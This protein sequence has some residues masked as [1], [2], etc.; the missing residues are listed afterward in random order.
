MPTVRVTSGWVISEGNRGRLAS[1]S[2]ATTARSR[3]AEPE[4]RTSSTFPTRPSA[5]TVKR[6]IAR[7]SS[8]RRLASSGNV[9]CSA[10]QAATAPRHPGLTV[11]GAASAACAGGAAAFGNAGAGAGVDEGCR[12]AARRV[13]GRDGDTARTGSGTADGGWGAGF[14]GEAAIRVSARDGRS[15]TAGVSGSGLPTSVA[16]GTGSARLGG[17]ASSGVGAIASGGGS[18]AAA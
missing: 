12:V 8:P 7:P 14:S 4:L 3:M 13:G 1:R 15:T 17:G 16:S 11:T 18:G 9:L 10:S 6:T 5:P 2:M